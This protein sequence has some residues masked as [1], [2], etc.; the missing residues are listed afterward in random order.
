M[1]LATHLVISSDT[2]NHLDRATKAWLIEISCSSCDLGHLPSRIPELSSVSLAPVAG[3][4]CIAKKSVQ[5]LIPAM[6]GA[7]A[8]EHVKLAFGSFGFAP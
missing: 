1:H 4:R 2:D 8:L 5:T 7:V 6:G 3:L